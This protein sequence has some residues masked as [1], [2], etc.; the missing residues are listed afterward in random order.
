MPDSKVSII[1]PVYNTGDYLRLCIASICNQ[2]YPKLQIIIVDDGSGEETASI[3]DELA[4]KDDRIELIHKP[5]EGVSVARNVGL[6][7][8]EGAIVC[9]V[10]SDDTIAHD[11]IERL[12][13]AIEDDDA[14]IAMCDATTIYSDNSTEDDSI[15]QLPHSCRLTHQAITPAILSEIAGSVCRCAY[16]RTET[17]SKYA[18][19]PIGIKFSED[20]IFNLIA[21][22]LANKITYLKEPYYNR[23]IRKGSACFRFYPD[24]TEQIE[25][26]REVLM[27]TVLNYW[28]SE[29]IPT[30]ERQVTGQILFAI[31]NYTSPDNGLSLKKRYS[32]LKDL[33][34]SPDIR[35][36]LIASGDK[37]LRTKLILGRHTATLLLIGYLT[38][39]Y[40]KL[41]RKGQYQQ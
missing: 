25:K 26:M 31:T 3:C 6:T 5:N 24:I 36:C 18:R 38:N 32:H 21:M 11:M 4:A 10:D 17:F 29:Y 27:A 30:F 34:T 16:R 20:R 39:L 22:G 9:F 2:T 8:A 19:F 12:V 14:D 41:C 37:S 35:E 33:C 13:R 15:R 1:I 23:L 28:G 7:M 40:H